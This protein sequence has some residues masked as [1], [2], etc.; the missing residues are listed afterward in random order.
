MCEDGDGVSMCEY[1]DGVSMCEDGDGVSMH[2]RNP[3][4]IIIISRF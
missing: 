1:G 4:S 3:P 2:T